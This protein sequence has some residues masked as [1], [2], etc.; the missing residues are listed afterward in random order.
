MLKKILKEG[1]D[2]GDRTGTGTRS[3]FGEQMKFNLQAGFPLLTTKKLHWKSIAHEL[4]WLISGETNIKYLQEKGVTIWNEWADENG[5]LG[6]VYG[7]QWRNWQVAQDPEEVI[8]K[9]GQFG[10]NYRGK[11]IDQLS[12]VI[13]RIQSKPEDRRLIV[14]AWNP[15]ETDRMKL[16][17]CHMMYQFY[18]RYDG[19]CRYLD[20]H[21]Y[22]RS[23]DVFLGVPYNIASYALLMH[24][25]CGI[26]G[27]MPGV[28]TISFG[29]IHIY[30]NHF[31]Q[32]YEQITRDPFKY[33]LPQIELY[34]EQ[35]TIDD[36]TYEDIKLVGYEAYP[37]I[38][39]EVAV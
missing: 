3:L 31:E 5:E 30:N 21:M 14:S 12:I 28:L 38:K 16:P 2:R 19:Q 6:P 24:L 11:F 9:R 29:D 34:G 15:G 27:D 13:E 37:S 7:Q 36:Y 23:A 17:P 32:V 22:Q 1:N 33:N 4:L 39:A 18:T 35:K 10:D 26:T 8:A 20:C 25:V